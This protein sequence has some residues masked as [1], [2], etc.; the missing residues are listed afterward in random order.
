MLKKF[1]ITIAAAGV[2]M[3]NVSFAVP[4]TFTNQVANPLTTDSS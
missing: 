1:L 2:I 4:P 3:L